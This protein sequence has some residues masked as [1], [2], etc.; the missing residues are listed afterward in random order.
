ML[1]AGENAI[2]ITSYIVQAHALKHLFT[3]LCDKNKIPYK[4]S[5][6]DGVLV[7]PDTESQFEILFM[8]HLSV[9]RTKCRS[10]KR[11][12]DNVDIILSC[13]FG[14]NVNMITAT[15]PYYKFGF[16]RIT[17]NAKALQEFEGL[18]SDEKNS[19]WVLS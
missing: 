18:T 7:F 2:C 8:S 10:Y 1:K 5:S 6:I 19:G 17:E 9:N 3:E 11:Y 14:D 4:H 13:I 12:I 15:G 16:K